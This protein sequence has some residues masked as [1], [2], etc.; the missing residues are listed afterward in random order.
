MK[1]DLLF[2]SSRR[3]AAHRVRWKVYALL[4]H[5]LGISYNFCPL[6]GALNPTDVVRS[7]VISNGFHF[8]EKFSQISTPL[9]S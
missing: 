7:A 6:M 1:T 9:L 5:L 3:T 4:V 2:G 8:S